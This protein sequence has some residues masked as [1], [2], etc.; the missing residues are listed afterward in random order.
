[1]L[2]L[3]KITKEYSKTI[4]KDITFTLGNREKVGLV[5]F[6]GSGK[7]TLMKII[8]KEEEPTKG[9][10]ELVQEKLG[11]LP[12]IFDITNDGEIEYLGEFMESLVEDPYSELWKVHK[13][14]NK[15]EFGEI[16]EFTLIDTFSPG[17][18][19]KLYLTKLMLEEPTILLFDEPTNHLDLNGILWME[20]FI[21][22]FRGITITISHDREFLN[23]TCNKIFEIDEEQLKIYE[24]NYDDFVI[25]KQRRLEDRAMQ[26]KLQE[27]RRKKLEDLVELMKKSG[28]GEAA[29]RRVRAAKTRL[30]REVNRQEIKEY[31][32]IRIKKL[33]I[34]GNVHGSKRILEVKDLDFAYEKGRPI[35]ENLKLEIYGSEKLWIK[36]DNGSGKSTLIKLITQELSYSKGQI[37]WGNNIRWKYFAQDQTEWMSDERVQEYFYKKTSLDW[38]KSYSVLDEFMFDHELRNQKI[39]S[40]SPGQKARLTFAIFAQSEYECLIL[41]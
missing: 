36:G 22:S 27:R 41:D 8:A 38:E 12:Q 7:S 10:V 3:E 39:S 19:M 21:N 29:G 1:M 5:G 34:K 26:I 9:S 6:N 2:K 4:F 33:D 18:K 24:G 17:K 25:E 13:I 31:K 40:L 37:T 15:L 16:D 32:E 23:S 11:Y 20:K 30:E 28:G 14:L 35:L